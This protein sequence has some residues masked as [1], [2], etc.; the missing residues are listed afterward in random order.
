MARIGRIGK[1]GIAL[2]IVVVL[3]VAAGA[4]Y[5]L[6][7]KKTETIKVTS[8]RSASS[9]KAKKKSS[10]QKSATD[11]AVDNNTPPASDVPKSVPASTSTLQKPYGTFVSNHHPSL[12]GSTAPSTEE[13]V[14]YAAPGATCYIEFTKGSLVK[15]LPAETA[16]SSGSVSW[17]W[18]IKQAGLSTGSWTIKAIASLNGKTMS[19]QDN[20]NLE[21]QP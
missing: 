15:R 13:S 16:D 10:D 3:I 9:E 11:N 4:A 5:L 17:N 2:T 6:T 19:A 8:T 7:H 14:C 12:D 18:D 1:K 20:L 21:V